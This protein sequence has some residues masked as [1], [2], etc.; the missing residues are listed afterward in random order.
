[1]A[2]YMFDNE[3]EYQIIL[4]KVALG[5]LEL[6][7]KDSS[8]E[9]YH[10]SL[11]IMRSTN[12]VSIMWLNDSTQLCHLIGDNSCDQRAFKIGQ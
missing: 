4:R 8:I 7:N 5:T 6:N 2:N 10:R 12:C 9:P 3:E 1:M 11:C